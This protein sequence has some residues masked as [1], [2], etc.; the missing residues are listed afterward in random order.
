MLVKAFFRGRLCTIDCMAASTFEKVIT[1]DKKTNYTLPKPELRYKCVKFTIETV[2]TAMSNG[3]CGPTPVLFLLGVDYRKCNPTHFGVKDVLGQTGRFGIYR[4]VL[5]SSIT[6]TASLLPSCSETDPYF[7]R[8]WGDTSR[9]YLEQIIAMMLL[10]GADAEAVAHAK[11][12]LMEFNAFGSCTTLEEA[13]I[14]VRGEDYKS[15]QVEG[16]EKGG[17]TTGEQIASAASAVKAHKDDPTKDKP[18]AEQQKLVDR[19]KSMGSQGGAASRTSGQDRGGSGVMAD[20]TRSDAKG[21]SVVRPG[22]RADA[23]GTVS[24][25]GARI[26]SISISLRSSGGAKRMRRHSRHASPIGTR[27]RASSSSSTN[28]LYAW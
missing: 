13:G 5:G 28:F 25:S 10:Q 2:L 19:M 11:S 18:T 1:K 26:W 12:E 21:K 4:F 7:G 16:G 9:A 23:P 17:A 3:V 22:F 15:P 14:G 27:A 20:G 8:N 24:K 6:V